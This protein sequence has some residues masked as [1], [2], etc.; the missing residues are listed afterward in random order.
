MIKWIR[1]WF[2]SREAALRKSLVSPSSRKTRLYLW[3]IGVV[4][5]SLMAVCWPLITG[6]GHKTPAFIFGGVE[7]ILAGIVIMVGGVTDLLSAVAERRPR[8]RALTVLVSVLLGSVSLGFSA[9][10]SADTGVPSAGYI[11]MSVALFTLAAAC[12]MYAVWLA[13]RGD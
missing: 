10:L 13:E 7:F 4:L 2:R 11:A 6:A 3:T 8:A 12:G 9:R 1:D 5:F